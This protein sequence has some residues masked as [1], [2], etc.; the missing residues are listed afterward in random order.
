[1][2][3][4]PNTPSL[5]AVYQPVGGPSYT[6]DGTKW[7]MTGSV[8]QQ[9]AAYNYRNRLVNPAFQISQEN[10]DVAGTTNAYYAADQW[11]VGFN[12]TGA[13]SWGRSTAAGHRPGHKLGRLP[14]HKL[15]LP[16]GSRGRALRR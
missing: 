2:F 15:G 1:M 9:A 16:R 8:L 6:W 4:F 13:I 5:G 3:N 11:V 12:T 14:R 7:V 10:A